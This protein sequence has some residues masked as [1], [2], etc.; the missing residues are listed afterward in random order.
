MRK[1]IFILLLVNLGLGSTAQKLTFAENRDSAVHYYVLACFSIRHTDFVSEQRIRK[2]LDTYD[3]YRV[4]CLSYFKT[5]VDSI[6][7]LHQLVLAAVEIDPLIKPK[8]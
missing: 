3:K 8:Q 2:T 7:F 4:I 1:L 5:H 6:A